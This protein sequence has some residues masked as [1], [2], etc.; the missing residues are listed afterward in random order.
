MSTVKKEVIKYITAHKIVD[1]GKTKLAKLLFFVDREVWMMTNKKKFLGVN[2]LRNHHGPLVEQYDYTIDEL[3]T[4]NKIKVQEMSPEDSDYTLHQIEL[5]EPY[6]VESILDYVTPQERKIID[7]VIK[8]FGNIPA[9]ALSELTHDETWS[10]LSN[11]AILPY[12]SYILLTSKKTKKL[13]LSRE[14]RNQLNTSLKEYKEEDLV[15]AKEL[16]LDDIFNKV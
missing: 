10:S 15:D 3:K 5:A 8:K 4:D 2:F 7:R 14:L 9:H 16:D 11:G 13:K 12:D 1:F 6:D